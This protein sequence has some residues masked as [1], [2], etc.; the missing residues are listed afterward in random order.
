MKIIFI[1]LLSLYFGIA[2]SQPPEKNKAPKVQQIAYKASPRPDR[3]ILSHGENSIYEQTVTWRTDYSITNAVAELTEL[4]SGIDFDDDVKK[5]KAISEKVITI[6]EIVQYHHVSFSDLEA[7]TYYAYRVGGNDYW[8]EWIQFKTPPNKDEAFSFI[9]MGDAQND[10]FTKWSRVVREAF[11]ARPKAKFMLHAG[12]L[13]NHAEN[14]YEWGEWFQSISFIS[15]VMPQFVVV[16]N[17]EYV[18]VDG[19]KTG[20]SSLVDPQ[21]NFPKNGIEGLDDTNYFM[22]YLNMKLVVLNS[23]EKIEEQAIWLD[24]VLSKNDKKWIVVSFHHPI[25]SGAEGRE[26]KGIMEHWK[27]ILDHYKVDLVLQGHDHVYG[28]GRSIGSEEALSNKDSKTVYVVSVSGRKMYDVSNHPWMEKK[29]QN[30]QFYQLID[31][32]DNQ[33]EYRAYTTDNEIFD[34]FRLTKSNGKTK[35]K[36]LNN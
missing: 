29:A 21:F 13:I 27:P 30:K 33:L 25:I 19:H 8:S 26:N 36:V 1:G 5:F 32:D 15:K 23:N 10:L 22:D 20:I 17:H 28:R 2:F 4:T 35:F 18:K 9:Y 12:D 6:D 16:G 31:I 34:A 24:E 11:M 3:I 7:D 14:N